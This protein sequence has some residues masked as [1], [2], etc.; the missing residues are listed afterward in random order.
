MQ[1]AVHHLLQRDGMILGICNGFQGLVKSGLLPYGQIRDLNADD[2]T[3]AHNAIG[4][5]ISQMVTVKVLNDNSPWLKGMKDHIYTIPVSHGE[6][7]FVARKEMMEDLFRKGQIATQYIDDDGNV[8]HGMPHNPNNS[9]FGVEGITSECGKIF[10]RMG[11]AERF[12]EGLM[13]NI[14]NANYHNIFKNGVEYFK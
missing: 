10:G 13:K 9:L 8:A 14:P 12:A 7:R 6:G 1:D 3:L 2:A 11:H 4:R 5:H